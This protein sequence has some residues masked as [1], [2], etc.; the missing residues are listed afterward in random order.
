MAAFLGEADFAGHPFGEV[1][2]EAEGVGFEFGDSGGEG[3]G[4]V[5]VVVEEFGAGVDD[6]FGFE[7]GD[8]VFVAFEG[9][10]EGLHG[11]AEGEAAFGGSSC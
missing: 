7:G 9:A 11:E 1:E 10:G 2:E 8:V 5:G 6:G 3:V 4:E